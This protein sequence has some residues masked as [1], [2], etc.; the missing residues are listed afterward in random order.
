MPYNES[1]RRYDRV[2]IYLRKSR[3]DLELEAVGGEDTLERHRR[4]LLELA[5]HYEL[6]VIRIYE[7]VVS[8]DTI[9]GRPQMQQLLRDVEADA[10]D[11]VL[12]HDIDRLGRGAMK[13]QGIILETFKWSHT[14]IITPDKIY[15][16]DADMDEEA[17]EFRTLS[18]RYEYRMIKKRLARGR[19]ASVREG[20]FIGHT[21]PYGYERY[22][23]ERQKGWSLR[24]VE[25]AASVVRDIYRW[26]TA[27][28]GSR[29]G[30][31]L[32]ARRLNDMGIPGP[33]GKDWTS[34][35]VRSILVNPEY[36]GFIRTGHRPAKKSMEGGE[37][38]TH[39]P[40]STD[41]TLYPGLH[42]AIVTK[43]QSD[44]AVSLL[45]KNKSRPGPKQVPM[46]NP[47]SGLVICDQC[48]RAMVRR[49]YSSGYPDGLLCPYSSCSCVSSTLETVEAA[50]LEGLRSWLTE[51]S[52]RHSERPKELA[53]LCSEESAS[54]V[55]STVSE[56]L[57]SLSRSVSAANAELER[58]RS[59]REKTYDL[60]EQGVYTPEVFTARMASLGDAITATEAQI[61]T[62]TQD[63]EKLKASQKARLELIPNVRRVLE[64]YELAETPEEKNALLRSVLSSVTYHKTRRERSRTGSDLSLTLHP[65]L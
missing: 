64:T 40:R 32:I 35:A 9:D 29:I 4:V 54:P 17:A 47:L 43:E 28:D 52:L 13:D 63:V 59:Q 65:L 45:S 8:G 53:P 5:R 46:K 19:E 2:A 50:I 27:E 7:E 61:E 39:R 60:V 62:M 36:A 56:D 11:A 55:P 41:P 23:L 6:T 10:Y 21:P 49:P 57:A 14:A 44:R 26:F 33:A 15:D 51:L 20:K 38:V 37:L 18:A 25:P 42:E 16:L 12:C 58:L 24:P 22:K 34:C 31:S 1:P 3:K 30:V 48:G